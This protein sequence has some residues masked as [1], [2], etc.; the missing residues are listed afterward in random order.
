MDTVFVVVVDDDPFIREVLSAALSAKPGVHVQCFAAAPDA[1]AAVRAAAPDI[2]VLDY[3]MPGTDGLAVLAELRTALTPLPPVFF[4]TAR[5]EASV[6]ARLRAEGAAVLAKPFDPSTIA[7]EILRRG[8]R[9][10]PGRD[11]RLD[12]VAARFR[13]SLPQT[14]AEIDKEWAVLRRE[15]QRPIAE[16]LAM[17]AHKLAG[18]AGLF[19]QY[20]FGQAARSVEGA[21]V[22]QLDAQARGE[23]TDLAAIELAM[24][25]L[26]AEAITATGKEDGAG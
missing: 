12:A 22:T 24:A 11:T 6:V 19:K 15:W 7:D 21:V 9:P 14:M 23:G 5:E 1:L 8:A 13:A 18:A 4:L 17:R 16:S 10:L 26:E 2:V 3:T 25:A 20:G